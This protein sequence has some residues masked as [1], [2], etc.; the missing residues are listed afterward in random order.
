MLAALTSCCLSHTSDRPFR[1]GQGYGQYQDS[2][3]RADVRLG[4]G[5]G[6]ASAFSAG[7]H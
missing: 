6:S 1:G 2:R 7:E 4:N 3:R 5:G